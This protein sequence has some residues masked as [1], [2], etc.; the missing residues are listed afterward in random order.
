MLGE[1]ASDGRGKPLSRLRQGPYDGP[2]AKREPGQIGFSVRRTGGVIGEHEVT[3]GSE[4][5]IVSLSHTALDR[6][7]FAHG[8]IKA[9]EWAAAQP[10]GLYDMSDVLGV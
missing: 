7:V 8:A 2:A 4:M 6:A 3:F 9:A 1:A 5:E 10:A